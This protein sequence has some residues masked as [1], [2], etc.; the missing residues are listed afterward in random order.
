MLLFEY[1]SCGN[2][3]DEAKR[4]KPNFSDWMMVPN[5]RVYRFIAARYNTYV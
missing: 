2:A 4:D 3:F 5:F 1:A